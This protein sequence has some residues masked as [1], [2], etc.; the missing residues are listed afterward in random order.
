MNT[1]VREKLLVDIVNVLE[2]LARVAIR[3]VV[4]VLVARSLVAKLLQ[5]PRMQC[6]QTAAARPKQTHP[7]RM[8]PLQ[9]EPK[10]LQ[11]RMQGLRLLNRQLRPRTSQGLHVLLVK[12]TILVRQVTRIAT[13]VVIAT[14]GLRGLVVVRNRRVH[15][16]KR[17]PTAR[18]HEAPPSAEQKVRNLVRDAVPVPL[19]LGLTKLIAKTALVAHRSLRSKERDCS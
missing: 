10:L 13:E 7:S 4:A 18:T 11:Q 16:I 17:V 2:I 5:S 19:N 9:L 3:V 8:N 1:L 14:I 6:E 15:L 12:R